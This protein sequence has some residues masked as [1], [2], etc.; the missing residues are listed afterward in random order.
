MKLLLKIL[1]VLSLIAFLL[2]NNFWCL[3]YD[4]LTFDACFIIAI[5]NIKSDLFF[6]SEVIFACCLLIIICFV[7]I[8]HK[9]FYITYS[10]FTVTVFLSALIDRVYSRN[11][12]SL[13][14]IHAFYLLIFLAYWTWFYTENKKRM[15]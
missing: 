2:L 9:V 5:G 4:Y 6:F 14:I 11:F 12:N 3:F 8:T 15:K 10:V 1:I 13:D 7:D